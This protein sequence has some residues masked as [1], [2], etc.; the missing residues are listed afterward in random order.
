MQGQEPTN[1]NDDYFQGIRG[2]CILSVV[3]IHC[4][5]GIQFKESVDLSFNYHYWLIL[6]QFI[7]FPVAIFI[8]LA[9]YFANTM[10]ATNTPLLFFTNRGK[11]LIIPFL[12]WSVFLIIVASIINGNIP[13]VFNALFA[14]VTGR[15]AGP[16]YFIPVLIQLTIITPLLVKNM[17]VKWFR[18]LCFTV[19]PL[20]LFV[21]YVYQYSTKQQMPYYE[22]PFPA[23]FLFYY[24]G[25]YI[26]AKGVIFLMK[27]NR[28]LTAIA[29]VLLALLASIFECYLLLSFGMPDSVASSQ[30]KVS[31]FLYAFA[32]LNMLYIVRKYASDPISKLFVCLGNNSYGI[33]YAHCF[34]IIF[35]YKVTSYISFLSQILPLYQLC[36]LTL[37]I[38]LCIL[39]I[40]ITKR[41]LG[42]KQASYLFGF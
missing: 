1:K 42:D 6:R 14:V 27:C 7:N 36:Q 41:L 18:F 20:Y 39:C 8:F 3:L 16:L 23:W 9:G 11:R 35:V 30:I 21:M 10:Q 13:T 37:T 38:V 34:W 26:K 22:I 19:T 12:I 32:V 29:L 31:S 4:T 24:A 5:T 33:Y 28:L 25:L 15:A 40:S 2:L 17:E